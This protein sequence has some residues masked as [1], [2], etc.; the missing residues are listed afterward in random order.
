VTLANQ[1][2]YGGGTNNSKDSA[3]NFRTWQA[4]LRM[5]G[6]AEHVEFKSS[7]RWD[8]REGK[9]NRDLAKVAGPGD[10]GRFGGAKR[11]ARS[12]GWPHEVAGRRTDSDTV[13]G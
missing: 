13:R 9:Q 5:G 2:R 1:L 10:L 3:H 6:E 8:Y 11:R 12:A 7:A 4:P